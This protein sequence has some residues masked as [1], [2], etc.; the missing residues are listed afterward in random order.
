MR[1]VDGGLLPESDVSRMA[2]VLNLLTVASDSENPALH[3]AVVRV[4]KHALE[5]IFNRM[6]VV[7]EIDR[8]AGK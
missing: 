2:D 8:E 1:C 4:A 5:P 3:A 6:V 7:C